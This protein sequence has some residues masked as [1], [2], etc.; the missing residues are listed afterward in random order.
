MSEREP[1]SGADLHLHTIYSDGAYTPEMLV[2]SAR[3]FGLRTIAVTDHDTVDGVRAV[4]EAAGDFPE[5]IPGVEFSTECDQSEV[6][7][8]GLFVDTQNKTLQEELRTY[9]IRREQRIHVILDKLSAMG[10]TVL[11]EDVFRYAGKGTPGRMHVALAMIARGHARDIG[12]AFG[13]YIGNGRP[14]YVA[15]ERQSPRETVEII[16]GAGGVSVLAHP[17][18]TQRDDLLPEL[19]RA[20]LQAVEAYCCAH[21]KQQERAYLRA[22]REHHLLVS[23]GSDCHG[24]NKQ[25]LLMGSVRLADEKVEQLRAASRAAGGERS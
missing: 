2:K 7:L 23:G 14:A 10:V 21:T 20:G 12:T 17:G 19:V 11:P 1:P 24:M 15:K 6:H 22:A 13:R 18:L 8:L 16:R 5:V 25:K 4:Q 9:R 3:S